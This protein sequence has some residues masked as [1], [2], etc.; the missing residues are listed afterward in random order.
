MIYIFSRSGSMYLLS[1]L[2]L[3]WIADIFAY[4]GGKALGRHKLAVRISPGKT[5]EGALIGLLGVMAWIAISSQWKGTYAADLLSR[6]GWPITI[7]TAALLAGVSVMGDLFE[8]L[9]KRRAGMKDSSAL[10]PGHGGVLDRID[11][12]IAVLPV[13][14]LITAWPK[15]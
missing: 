1:L 5:I 7:L 14:F 15:S 12:V 6:W 13:A 8:S 9:L 3:I 4:F 11:A 10:L 2:T